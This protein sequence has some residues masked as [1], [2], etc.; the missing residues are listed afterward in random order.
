VE[1]PAHLRGFGLELEPADDVSAA[2]WLKEALRP[3]P[4]PSTDVPLTVASFVP[5]SHEAFARIL[6][7][8]CHGIGGGGR[9]SEL[10]ATR[11][12]E[13]GAETSFSEASGLSSRANEELWQRYQ[14]SDGSLPARP[15]AAVGAALAPHTR[16]PDD[17][18]FCFWDGW[19]VWVSDNGETYYGHLTDEENE[20]LNAPVRARWERELA[21][22]E[23]L[24]RLKLPNREHYLFTG[25]LG[26]TA[27]P[28][29]FGMWE[30]SPSMWW[31]ADR[32][33]FVATEVDGF[34]TY[35]GGSQAAIAA[36]LASPE[37]EAVAVTAGTSMD[38]GPFA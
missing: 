7:P 26:R 15:M 32:A 1:L 9:W 3:W 5:D 24:P 8:L 33:W 20:A 27:R 10:A 17:C 6:H 30:Q 16:T 23:P 25:P 34:S 12:V 4:T 19:G 35:A 22:L 29:A 18:V 13:I 36:V 14:P 2:D 21:A 11:G 28:F 31:P 37:L 38:P